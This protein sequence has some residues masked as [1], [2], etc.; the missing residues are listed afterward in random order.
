MDFITGLSNTQHGHDSIWVIMDCLT[1]IAHFVPIKID[2]HIR[3]YAELYVSQIMRLHGVPRSIISN[4]G[5]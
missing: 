1:K 4:R 2:Y 5:P 3:K